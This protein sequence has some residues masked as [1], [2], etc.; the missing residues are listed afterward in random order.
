MKKI[1][2]IGALAA[3]SLASCKPKLDSNTG[4]PSK[5][6]ADFTTYVAVGNSLTAGYADG[7]LYRTGQENSYPSMLA[8]QFKLVGGT[9]D[10]VQPLLPGES[11]W[12]GAKYVLVS[13]GTS[14]APIPYP[15]VR[16]TAGSSANVALSAG[17][18]NTGIPGI[19]AVDYLLPGYG[20]PLN[21]NPYLARLISNPY[22]T[23]LSFALTKPATFYSVWVGSNDVLAYATSGGI[24]N[25][26]TTALLTPQYDI[27]SIANFTFSYDSIVNALSANGAKGILINIPDV[28][29]IPFFTTVPYNALS[30][31]NA[32][33][34]AQVPALNTAYAQLNQVFAAVGHPERQ[35]SF[36]TS[37]SSAV[38]IK[39]KDLTNISAQISGAL[40]LAGLPAAQ[41]GLYGNLY[42]QAR[43]AKAGELVLLPAASVIGTLD[44][45][46]YASLLGAGIPAASAA[47]LATYGVGEPL[48]DGYVLT[49]N[50]ISNVTSYTTQFNAVI[51]A[52]AVDK[53]WGLVDMNTYL[54][55]ITAGIIYNGVSFNAQFVQGGAFS[56]DGVHLTPRGYAI[57]ANEMLRVINSTY[58]ATIPYIDINSKSGIKF[59]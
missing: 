18:N 36:S 34:A 56:L 29:A 38:V 52:K 1:Y 9:G 41:A 25:V 45:P 27:P 2:I 39:D 54:K 58:S 10:F 6:T 53:G 47:G 49:Q 24:G 5:G 21:G 28:T 16:D 3:L 31:D 57:A 37:G 55:T 50:E 48:A 8:T 35:I 7:S 51:A 4:M 20:N 33:F 26:G 42:G 19:R 14:V 17:Y 46:F 30:T 13:T 59:P 43:Q 11:G 32:A 22:Q 44:T 12:P 23:A 40:Q 15:G